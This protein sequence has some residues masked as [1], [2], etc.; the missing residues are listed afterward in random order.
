MLLPTFVYLDQ[1]H[2]DEGSAAAKRIA[3]LW[4]V[5][6]LVQ[7]VVVLAIFVLHE[8]AGGRHEREVVEPLLPW[9]RLVVGALA[10]GLLAVAV[11]LWPLRA[12]GFWPWPL[13]D[14]GAGAM[15]TWLVAFAAG[16]AWTLREA[17]W[18]RVRI[19]FPV[20]IVFLVLLLVAALRFSDAFDGGAWQTWTWVGA[21]VLSI[22]LLTLG[23]LQQE[24][25]LAAP[26]RSRRPRLQNRR[27]R[28]ARHLPRRQRAS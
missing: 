28:R 18:R 21:I 6:Y 10:I 5:L 23:A 15:A 8:R 24:R 25:G 3:W 1:F 9:L 7:P 26:R 22:G 14:L 12:D 2:L 13:T 17:D 19:A 16:A 4:V 27:D 11:A 20:N